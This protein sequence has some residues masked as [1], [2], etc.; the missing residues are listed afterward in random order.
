MPI[1]DQKHFNS[2]SDIYNRNKYQKFSHNKIKKV[3]PRNDSNSQNA[4]AS[5]YLLKKV[6]I[7]N[8]R[9]IKIKSIPRPLGH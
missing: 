2:I 4:R 7:K 8:Q 3:K 5:L 1:A 6:E 9:K